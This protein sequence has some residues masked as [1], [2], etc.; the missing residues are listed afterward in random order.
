MGN[1]RRRVYADELVG[2]AEIALRLNVSDPHVVHTWRERHSDFPEP[3]ARLKRAMVWAWPDVEAWALSSGRLP[4][5][6]D[7]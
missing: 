3:V 5:G 1:P 4:G 2:A 6:S 7:T